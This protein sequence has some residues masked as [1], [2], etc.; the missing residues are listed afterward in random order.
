MFYL[1]AFVMT[2]IGVLSANL[3]LLAVAGLFAIAGAIEIH[4]K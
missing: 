4:K 3:N 1:V 2:A